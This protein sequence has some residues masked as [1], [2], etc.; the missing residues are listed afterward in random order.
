[1]YAYDDAGQFLDAKYSVE[2]DEDLLALF[3]ESSGGPHGSHGARNSDY[4]RALEVLLIRLQNLDAVL[5]DALVDSRYTQQRG[6]P[7][8]ER[9]LL[10][11]PLRLATCPNMAE[12]RLM[13]THN[14]ARIGQTRA[15]RDGNTT[16]RIRLR[17]R[18]PGFGPTDP[19]RLESILA[20]PVG[21][22]I[23][24]SADEPL[25][26]PGLLFDEGAMAQVTVN[27]YERDPRARKECLDK[28]GYKCSVCDLDFEKR[29]GELGRGFIHVHHLKELSTVGAG[30]RVNPLE[31]LRPVCP[32]CHAMLH[33]QRP[34]LLP[35]E[36][37]RR[38][39]PDC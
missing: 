17:L 30:Y 19:H 11:H 24:H 14:Q 29:Y 31:D 10:S 36:L 13:L 20:N 3:L 38:L 27:K 9:R 35:E 28:F 23:Y 21:E 32:N 33:R 18:I 4:R 26:E 1:M 16:K 37:R 12:V 22:A 34:A 25:P 6:L 7:E 15:T 8:E 5:E 39:A 2:S